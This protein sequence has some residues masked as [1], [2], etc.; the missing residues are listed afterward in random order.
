MFARCTQRG[1]RVFA[2]AGGVGVGKHRDL[3]AG[4]VRYAA[5]TPQAKLSFDNNLIKHLESLKR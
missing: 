1:K 3:L 4:R 2:G 5:T